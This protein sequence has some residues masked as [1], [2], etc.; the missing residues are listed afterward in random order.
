M[1]NKYILIIIATPWGGLSFVRMRN[2][3]RLEKTSHLSM[4]VTFLDVIYRFPQVFG[5]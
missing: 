5:K 4:V 1:S 2:K 3:K